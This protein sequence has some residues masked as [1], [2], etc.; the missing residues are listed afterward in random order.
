M[1]GSNHTTLKGCLSSSGG[2]YMLTDAAGTQ[3]QL[4]GD[5]SKLSA[6]VNNE[7]EVKGSAAGM[8]G[9]SSSAG[10]QTA[11]GPAGGGSAQTF[12]VTKVKKLSS[13]CSTSK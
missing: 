13:N 11:A 1:S 9:S 2:G 6:H 7:V 4:T 8:S 5:T 3:Y 10:S 12:N